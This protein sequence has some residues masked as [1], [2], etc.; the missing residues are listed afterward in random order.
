[1]LP[2]RNEV[3]LYRA[4]MR[5]V[6]TLAQADL[7]ALWRTLNP[8]EAKATEAGLAKGLPAIIASYHLAAASVTADW[9]DLVRADA[10][11]RSS[12]Q[13]IIPEPPDAGRSVI[14]AGW[15]VSPLF[16]VARPDAALAKVSG[17]MQRVILDGARQTVTVSAARDPARPA[18]QRVASADACAYCADRAGIRMSDDVVFESHDACGCSA[19]PDF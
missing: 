17:G 12:F 2:P 15:A 7:A 3:A 8:A 14:L 13:A 1:M 5:D 18:W 10:G 16:G 9:Y 4:A 6:D 19:V 11:I